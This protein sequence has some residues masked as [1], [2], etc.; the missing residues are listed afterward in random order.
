MSDN[1]TMVLYLL[2]RKEDVMDGNIYTRLKDARKY[3]N[4]TQEYVAKYVGIPRTAITSIESGQKSISIDELKKFSEI[5]GLSCDQII[6]GED[7]NQEV[8]EYSRIYHELPERD[9]MEI[10]NLLEFKKNIRRIN[11]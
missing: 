11:T 8:K 9:K 10:H 7:E 5:Y 1:Q 4:L 3:L 2:L 6:H